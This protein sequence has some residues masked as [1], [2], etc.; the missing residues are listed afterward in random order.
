MYL[1]IL[2][3]MLYHYILCYYMMYCAHIYIILCNYMIYCTHTHTYIH[4]SPPNKIGQG[5]PE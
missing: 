5:N 3:F 1:N 4:T 2:K